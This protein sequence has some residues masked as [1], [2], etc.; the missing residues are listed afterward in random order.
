MSIDFG[1]LIFAK[2]KKESLSSLK[3][4]LNIGF[5]SDSW[6]DNKCAPNDGYSRETIFFE[7][8]D[9]AY[10]FVID[11]SIFSGF[12]SAERIVVLD[13]ATNT[14]KTYKLE[15]DENNDCNALGV[16]QSSSLG[17][18]DYEVVKNAS[19]DYYEDEGATKRYPQLSVANDKEDY[20]IVEAELN[21]RPIYIVFKINENGLMNVIYCDLDAFDPNSIGTRVMSLKEVND[22]EYV[23]ALVKANKILFNLESNNEQ[24]TNFENCIKI[25]INEMHLES[26]EQNNDDI[27]EDAIKALCEEAMLPSIPKLPI[28][29]YKDG[30]LTL[31]TKEFDCIT[32]YLVK[33][34]LHSLNITSDEDLNN[35]YYGDDV[36]D[37]LELDLV[38]SGNVRAIDAGAFHHRSFKSITIGEGVETIGRRAFSEC[39]ANSIQL[40]TTI[41]KIYQ[42]A[43]E[44]NRIRE[45]HLPKNLNFISGNS[46]SSCPELEKI[47]IDENN[48]TYKTDSLNT[49]LIEKKEDRLIMIA[50]NVAI[51]EGIKIIGE[52]SFTRRAEISKLVIPNGVE[53][54]E[55]GAFSNCGF[56]EIEFPET[57]LE[58]G[59]SAF[60]RCDKLTKLIFPKGLKKIDS[61]A[62]RSCNKLSDVYLSDSVELGRYCFEMST[63]IHYLDKN[64]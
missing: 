20:L 26:S 46:F 41:N 35:Y 57:L 43:F 60:S 3:N 44:S 8:K 47:F 53:I 49:A 9:Y 10:N 54:I 12:V 5:E 38:I 23:I 6:Y 28:A 22:E 56:T 7:T 30:T 4:I 45:I 17:V 37:E 48:E 52:D 18:T 63:N 31:P 15:E 58:I 34:I 25:R 39:E 33:F 21:K 40:P 24:S 55:S 61:F 64:S 16:F 51:P 14:R 59:N 50:A 62:F 13:K 32:N 2:V 36:L 29:E 11:N 27:E 42:S 19:Y 1:G